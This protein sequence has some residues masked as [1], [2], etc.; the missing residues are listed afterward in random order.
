M[1]AATATVL[2]TA[3]TLLAAAMPTIAKRGI[4][5]LGITVSNLDGG[6][7]IQ[8]ELPLSERPRSRLDAALDEI[9]KRFGPAAVTRAALVGRG[10]RF[11]P[12]LLHGD[13]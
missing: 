6:G 7:A 1:S 11:T 9:R 13:E 8:L 10:E 2:V 3:R 12:A 4:T 5:L